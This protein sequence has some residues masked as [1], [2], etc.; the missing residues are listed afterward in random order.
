MGN[1]WACFDSSPRATVLPS[2]NSKNGSLCWGC[3]YQVGKSVPFV[4]ARSYDVWWQKNGFKQVVNRSVNSE[5]H[6]LLSKTVECVS[7]VLWA[8]T[9]YFVAQYTCYTISTTNL[10]G[11]NFV[12]RE[13]SV[14]WVIASA[15]A[16]GFKWG[17][18]SRNVCTYVSVTL[19]N[20]NLRSRA[21]RWT[22]ASRALTH[23]DTGCTNMPSLAMDDRE[24]R[25]FLTIEDG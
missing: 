13:V 20:V 2:N 8:W 14:V 21:R 25:R 5:A 11:S 6:G 12:C 1:T 24:E 17:T 15:L 23:E 22:Q 4:V 19:R 9:N 18:Y 7:H 3:K 16:W 10:I